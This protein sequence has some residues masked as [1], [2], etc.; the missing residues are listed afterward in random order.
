MADERLE[1][2]HCVICDSTI[3]SMSYGHN[4]EPV[5]SEG[6]CC[7]LCN[8]MVV[9]PARLQAHILATCSPEKKEV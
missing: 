3:G 5:R 4:P 6:R 9:I 7:D 2:G 8:A 1:Q